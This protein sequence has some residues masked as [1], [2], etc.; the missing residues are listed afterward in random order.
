[1]RRVERLENIGKVRRKVREGAR[2]E[3]NPFFPSD[4]RMHAEWDARAR[5]RV[6][7]SSVSQLRVVWKNVNNSY[8]SHGRDE[9]IRLF[10]ES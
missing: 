8:V 9:L 3:H 2:G 5:A 1:M 7:R 10:K 6:K 4:N